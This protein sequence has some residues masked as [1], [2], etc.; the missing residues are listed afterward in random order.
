MITVALQEKLGI[1][2][3]PARGRSTVPAFNLDKSTLLD[4][5]RS[6]QPAE[7]RLRVRYFRP[8]RV[9]QTSCGVYKPE[10]RKQGTG[11]KTPEEMAYNQL[12]ATQRAAANIRRD[13]LT[14]TADRMV[15]LTYVSNMTDRLQA[16]QHLRAWIRVMRR[17]FPGWQSLSVMEFQKRGA[18]H[19]HVALTGFYDIS[20][21]RREWQSIIGE[22]S[23]VNLAFSPD[24]KGNCYAKLAAY[25][26]KYLAKDSQEG[27]KAGEHRYFRTCSIQRPSEVFY[28]PASAP[29]T[30]EFDLSYEII[31]TLLGQDEARSRL[32]SAAQGGE[33]GGCSG[34]DL[35]SR[36][37]R[38]ESNIFMVGSLSTN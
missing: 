9:I 4:R 22:K 35:W 11:K 6:V 1:V 16:L 7:R 32:R 12:R 2:R 25:M 17:E 18:I 34:V 26:A 37:V 15:T 3:G 10:Q 20:V 33:P 13:L 31:T 30:E 5:L 23:I 29:N 14:M 28:I 24:G 19:F 36:S 38:G 8:A 27:R 21:L